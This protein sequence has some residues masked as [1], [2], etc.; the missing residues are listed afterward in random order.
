MPHHETASP[1]PAGLLFYCQQL[2]GLLQ[3]SQQLNEKS[4]YGVALVHLAL[5]AAGFRDH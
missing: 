3:L 1:F 5:A 4:A 2:L